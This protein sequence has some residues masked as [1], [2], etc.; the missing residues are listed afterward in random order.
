MTNVFTSILVPVD[1]SSAADRA[2]NRAIALAEA[3]SA[4]LTIVYIVDLNTH[5][6]AFEQVSGGGYIPEEIKQKGYSVLRDAERRLP[7]SLTADILLEIG[8]PARRILN[9]AE[10]KRADLIVMGSRGLS[11]AKQ[12]LLG[13]VSQSVLIR[14]ECPVMIIR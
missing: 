4:K 13:S 1:G 6:S 14:A 11:K 3:F 12:I 8:N 10:D 7:S 2:L 5:M 9:I